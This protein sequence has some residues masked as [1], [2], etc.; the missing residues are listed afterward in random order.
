[1]RDIV[2]DNAEVSLLTR[3][4]SN[5]VKGLLIAL[6]VLGH[7]K[8]VMQGG[9]SNVYLYSFHVYA[10]YYLPFLY[11]FRKMAWGGFF[12]K[13]LVRLYVPYTVFF[14]LV[15]GVAFTQHH[16]PDLGTAIWTY[17]CGS[18]YSLSRS[19]GFG[20]F[21]WFLPTMLSVLTYRQIYY[22]LGI[23][24]RSL[25][26]VLSGVCL[27]GFAYMW[28]WYVTLWW[29]SPFC[30][31][32]GLSMLLPAV[33]LR[34][35]CRHVSPKTLVFLFFLLTVAILIFYPVRL[36][37]NLTF[38]TINRL[39]CPVLIFSLLL[40][41][42]EYLAQSRIAVDL[43]V[44]SLVIYLTHQFI[45]NGC[46]AGTL[47]FIPHPGIYEGLLM[48]VVA[49]GGGYLISLFKPIRYVFPK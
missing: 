43:G 23:T 42:R 29:K 30:L 1:M 31:A 10:F 41:L 21:L 33:C 3:E 22:R 34:A 37:Y 16:L 17:I 15:C 32:V 47:R 39:M 2:A 18:Q 7:N 13:N 12:R 28:G 19:F 14:L 9:M 35:V 27:C 25:M 49:L 38:L 20:S 5:A 48:F 46:Y 8:Y 26:L 45:Y 24:G 44:Q 40:T 11:D 36:E 4:Q 6:V